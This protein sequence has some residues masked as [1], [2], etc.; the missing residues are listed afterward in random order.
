MWWRSPWL[1]RRS[2]LLGLAAFDVA[3]V[4]GVYNLVYGIRLSAW[5][6][7]SGSVLGLIGLWLSASYLIGRYSRP[8]RR[9]SHGERWLVT[10]GVALL[11][12]SLVAGGLGWGLDL[13]D[14]RTLRGFVLPTVGL[15]ALLSALAQTRAHWLLQKPQ[16]WIL[17]GQAEEL[18]VLNTELRQDNLNSSLRLTT[19]ESSDVDP[20]HLFEAAQAAA[21]IAVSEQSTLDETSL[22]GLLA[23]RGEGTR[24]VSL[25]NWAEQVLQRVPPELFNSRWLVHA[26]GFELQPER[27]SWRVKRLGDLALGGLLLL[28][29]LPVVALAALL[30]KL[31]DGGPVFYRQVRTGLYGERITILKLR[32]MAIDAEAQGARWAK[33]NDQRITTIGRWLRRLR[34]DELPQLLS[35]L[36]GE[37][38]LIGPRPERP[39]LEEHLEGAIPHYRVRHWIRPGLSGWAQVCHPYG[40]SVQDSR[41]KLSYDLYYLRNASLPLDLLIVFK[42]IRLVFSGKGA[43]P[44]H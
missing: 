20:T 37:M 32:S 27:F 17:I 42:T 15:I 43:E 21:G 1:R 23:L 19:V 28:A 25:V 24:V 12:L 22:Q 36:R 44:K 13:D 6:G 5:P 39:E 30:V 11:V 3:A 16:Q 40:A 14:P 10:S 41:Q 38:S 31:E 33:A 34:I 29:T 7:L 9:Q 26:E 2:L 4:I 35:V 8:R 18:K